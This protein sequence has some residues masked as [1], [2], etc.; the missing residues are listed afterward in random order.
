MENQA[1]L[2]LLVEDDEDDYLLTRAML[3]EARGR[4]IE[5]RWARDIRSAEA[6]LEEM[7]P[8]A[9][10]ADYYLQEETGLDLLNVIRERGLRLP[11]ILLTGQGSYEVD[12]KAMQAGAADYISKREATSSLLERTIRYAIERHRLMAEN[13]EQKE[14]AVRRANELKVVLRD[15]ERQRALLN[16]II[17][18]APSG[19]MMVDSDTRI[20]LANP[21]AEQIYARGIPIGE[22][23]GCLASAHLTSPAGLVCAEGDLPL[24]QCVR[25]GESLNNK[26]FQLLW[27]DG[28]RRF[29]LSN[30]APL[31]DGQDQIIGAV[32]VF[33]D[34]TEHKL[35]AD[36]QRRHLAQIE[37]QRHLMQ[38]REKERL[39]IAQDLHDGPLQ[40]LV[41]MTFEVKGLLE[42]VREDELLEKITGLEMNLQAAI[43]ELRTFTGMLRPPALAPFGLEKAIQSHLTTFRSQHPEFTIHQNLAVDG[44]MLREDVRLALY[45]IYQEL[46][47]NIVR[48]AEASEIWITLAISAVEVELGVRDNGC[49]F[50]V[51]ENWVELARQG[52]LGLVGVQE[53]AQAVGGSVR[54]VSATGQGTTVRVSVPR[55]A[56]TAGF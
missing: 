17:A 39:R 22:P 38:S 25:A 48:H 42:L 5:L 34:I 16:A 52:H 20:V 54:I 18:N 12:L 40:S 27:P 29:I 45:R 14:L 56:E 19:I 43:Q 21:V 2:I 13:L 50:E 7:L 51:P 10:L 1:W 8:D 37:V 41:G 47:N 15:L 46:L 28:Q 30:T 26:E 24:V 35:A 3:K 36:E 23:A 33:A 32:T 44:Q 49:G 11:V 53:R 4:K 31:R 55:E 6:L 9:V